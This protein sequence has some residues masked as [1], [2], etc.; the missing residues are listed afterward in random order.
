ML[1]SSLWMPV[2]TSSERTSFTLEKRIARVTFLIFVEAVVPTI[3][4]VQKALAKSARSACPHLLMA[5][6]F[7]K[8]NQQTNLWDGVLQGKCFWAELKAGCALEAL[9][10]CSRVLYPMKSLGRDCI[11]AKIMANLKLASSV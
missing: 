3:C 4:P 6:V 9:H 10:G 5:Q 2:A 11:H 1:V 8:L 7:H